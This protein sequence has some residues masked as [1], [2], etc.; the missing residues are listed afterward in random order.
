MQ[1][2]IDVLSTHVNFGRHELSSFDLW[3]IGEF[4]REN[5]A[6]WLDRGHGLSWVGI[7]GWEDFH[8]VCGD[9]DIPWATGDRENVFPLSKEP[10]S[11]VGQ[12]LAAEEVAE[13][14]E[15]CNKNRYPAPNLSRAGCK[16]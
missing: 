11:T 12:K 8:A 1:P 3:A 5:I 14:L 16:Q 7:Y 9:I 15:M 4:T 10:V 2:Y 13:L 6:S